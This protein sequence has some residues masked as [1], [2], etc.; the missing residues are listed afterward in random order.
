LCTSKELS[1]ARRACV[2]ARLRAGKGILMPRCFLLLTVLLLQTVWSNG[3]QGIPSD[4]KTSGHHRIASYLFPNGAGASSRQADKNIAFEMRDKPWIGEKGSV[5]EWLSDQTGMPVSISSAKPTGTLTFINPHAGGP[6]KKY[7]LGEVID[8]LNGEL[9]KQKLILV[10]RAR[11]FSIEPADEKIDPAVLPRVSPAELDQYGD[12]ELVSVVFPLT[13]LV[14]EDFALEV[15]GMLGPFG[16]VVSLG[17]ANKLVVQDTAANLR[18]IRAIVRD[19]EDSEKNK[20][21]SFSHACRY[22]KARHAA[23]ILRDLLGDPKELLRAMQPQQRDANGGQF[24]AA[25]EIPQAIP[26]N[27][28]KVRMHYISVDEASNT[29]LVTGPADK[30]AQAEAI[31]KKIDLPQQDGQKP[32]LVGPPGFKTY[33]VSGGSAEVLAK[34]LQE[35]YKDAPAVRVAAVGNHSIMVW[36]GPNDQAEIFQ[37][38]RAAKEQDSALEVIPLRSLDPGDTVDILKGMFGDT[39][40]GAPYLKADTARRALIAKGTPDQVAEIKYALKAL[41]EGATSRPEDRRRVLII[42]QGNAAAVAQELQRVL[43]QMIQNPIYV[44]TPGAK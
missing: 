11:T 42:E 36:A 44:V 23:R 28:S 18:R 34:S 33:P 26:A 31:I 2:P 12:T 43:P 17:Q 1:L 16:T 21:A 15:K 14:A 24:A 25:F 30:I 13:S 9:L 39:R 38:I 29:V 5:L 40:L 10:R 3:A 41:G 37:H 35:I 6:P 20:M 4:G 8:I 7:S 19:S 22:I 27:A 32:V